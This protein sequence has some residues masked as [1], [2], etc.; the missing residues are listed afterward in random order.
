MLLGKGVIVQA[1]NAKLQKE[2]SLRLD[3]LKISSQDSGISMGSTGRRSS[4]RNMLD[5]SMGRTGPIGLAKRGKESPKTRRVNFQD[6]MEIDS[7]DEEDELA[8]TS[9]S[10]RLAKV[11]SLMQ[12]FDCP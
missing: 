1:K 3:P 12:A 5:S 4:R 7:S 8:E 9:K 2:M 10:A 6:T 11:N